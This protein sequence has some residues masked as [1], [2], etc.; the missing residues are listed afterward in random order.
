MEI[1]YL[2]VVDQDYQMKGEL[3]LEGTDL[4]YQHLDILSQ[5]LHTEI[6][7]KFSSFNHNSMTAKGTK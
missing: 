6:E 3:H 2:M 5:Q 4:Y 1:C 7:N